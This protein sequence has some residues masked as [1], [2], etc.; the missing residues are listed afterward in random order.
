M[1]IFKAPRITTSQRLQLTFGESELI[2]DV[3]A[4][5]FFGGDGSSVGG[6][7]LGEGSGVFTEIIT[8]TQ[9]DIDNKFITLSNL[10]LANITLT[11]S[12]GPQQIFGIDFDV[13][14]L[15]V[16]WDNLGLDGFLEVNDV[17]VIQY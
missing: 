15:I 13:V 8:L 9:N 16:S 3:D 4:K 6:F 11:P 5:K 7:P 12:G 14:G 1:A 2:Y 10:P 17:L